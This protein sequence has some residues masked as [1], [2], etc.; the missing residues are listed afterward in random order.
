DA[1]PA[2]PTTPP[3]PQPYE[4]V[5]GDFE[6]R[7]RFSLRSNVLVLPNGAVLP[8]SYRPDDFY[9]SHYLS[10]H[11]Q[12]CLTPDHQI[13]G[14]CVPVMKRTARFFMSP[15]YH[16]PG[17]R[18][19]W[20]EFTKRLIASLG[21]LSEETA[22]SLDKQLQLVIERVIADAKPS[23]FH[24][25]NRLNENAWLHLKLR[26][27]DG[28]TLT[29]STLWSLEG[30]VDS[31]SGAVTVSKAKLHGGKYLANS[32]FPVDVLVESDQTKVDQEELREGSRDKGYRSVQEI[33]DALY[34]AAHDLLYD[35]KFQKNQE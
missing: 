2:P 6:L 21:E 10:P 9:T 16:T 22:T 17:T 3:T 12:Y 32:G 31:G 34:V 19:D 15:G 23:V 30:T 5:I 28:Y 25:N 29:L 11:H 33:V 1:A 24:F 7:K 13:M 8:V 35:Y 14:H 18:T 20:L 4:I 26:T 27:M